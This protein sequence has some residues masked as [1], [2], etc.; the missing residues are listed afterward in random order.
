MDNQQLEKRLPFAQTEYV[1]V[2]F[3]AA[4]TDVIIRY[5]RLTPEDVEDI[6]WIDITP[7]SVYVN[8]TDSPARVYRSSKP[9]RKAFGAN[10]IVLRSTVANYTTRLM[11]FV[12]K[13][14]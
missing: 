6:R 5:E 4:D 8:P 11:L 2:E 1:D 9:G 14:N 10:Y 12:E 3:G 13:E 7:N